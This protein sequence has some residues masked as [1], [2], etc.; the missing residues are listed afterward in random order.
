MTKR[1]AA[2]RSASIHT[3]REL[4]R[5]GRR[6]DHVNVAAERVLAAMRRGAA[7]H[8]THRPN[9]TRWA[10]SNG[11]PVSDEVARAVITRGDVA[12]VGDSLFD[13]GLSQ[14]WRYVETR[15]DDHV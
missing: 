1:A 13:R 2:W 7:L 3:P 10:L 14:T 11:M 12:G 9:S 6:L 15:G 8:C 5:K 4:A